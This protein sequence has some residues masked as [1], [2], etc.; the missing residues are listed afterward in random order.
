MN[1]KQSPQSAYR[2]PEPKV[3]KFVSKLL[4][5]VNDV[6]VNDI[7]SWSE[8]GQSFRIKDPE[9]FIKSVLPHYF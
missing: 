2:A 5:V 3:S 9:N 1:L 8:D 7:V 4:D 6:A